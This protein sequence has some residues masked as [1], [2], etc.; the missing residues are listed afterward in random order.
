M[1]LQAENSFVQRQ[2]SMK[3][4]GIFKKYQFS[5]ADHNVSVGET[6]VHMYFVWG[7]RVGR[8]MK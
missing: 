2:G 6:G 5:M 8:S 7:C 3:E 1:A 4:K